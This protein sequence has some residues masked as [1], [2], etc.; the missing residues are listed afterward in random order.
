MKSKR[1]DFIGKFNIP[2][3]EE[4]EPKPFDPVEHQLEI[5]RNYYH[6]HKEEIRVEKA[7]RAGE[8][9]KA[10]LTAMPVK[11]P[12]EIDAEKEEKLWKKREYHRKYQ[13]A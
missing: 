11:T 3:Y 6:R 2:G 9:K 7:I 5:W 4:P 13:R 12:E 8:K 10:K 1:L